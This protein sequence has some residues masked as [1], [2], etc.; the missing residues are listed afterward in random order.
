M[1][2]DDPIEPIDAC[3]VE[4]I[5]IDVAGNGFDLTDAGNGT[6]FDHNADGISESIAWIAAGS[7]DAFLVLDRDHDGIVNN[8]LEWFG[9]FTQQ[10]ASPRP[11]GFAALKEFDTRPN[12]GNEDGMIS[13]ADAVYPFL[14]LWHDAN[15]NG[16]SEPEEL[17][18]LPQVGLKSISLDYKVLPKRDKFGNR[19]RYRAKLTWDDKKSPSRW[20]YDVFFT[21]D[22]RSNSD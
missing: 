19:F 18:T 21:N 16:V 5:V 20:A 13:E 9:N 2:V 7:D 8:G 15:H 12:G 17:L 22:C 14:R 6:S 10:T 4:P 11:N 3:A 1:P